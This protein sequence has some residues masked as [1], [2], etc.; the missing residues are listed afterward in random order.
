VLVSEEVPCGLMAHAFEGTAGRELVGERRSQRRYLV[1]R[2]DGTRRPQRRVR[3][4]L[5]TTQ[6]KDNPPLSILY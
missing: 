5:R 6:M 2:W 4:T 1:G 3:R